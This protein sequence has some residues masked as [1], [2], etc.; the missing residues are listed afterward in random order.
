VREAYRR[1]G[2]PLRGDDRARADEDQRE[3]PDE[4]RS[5]ALEEI[6]LPT[7]EPLERGANG[8]RSRDGS[9][10]R[11]GRISHLASLSLRTKGR[12][13]TADNLKRKIRNFPAANLSVR[14]A[15]A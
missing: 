8:A 2:E 6:G 9:G 5:S 1:E 4:L 15:A 12:A 14:I 7:R 3:G 11:G 13:M 10:R